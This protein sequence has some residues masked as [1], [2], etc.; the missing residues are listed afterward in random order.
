LEQLINNFWLMA[1]PSRL[2]LRRGH[3]LCCK[4]GS[5]WWSHGA[6]HRSLGKNLLVA[7][8]ASYKSRF[9][10][11]VSSWWRCLCVCACLGLI[12]LC[13]R[14]CTLLGELTCWSRRRCA[15]LV[16]ALHSNAVQIQKQPYCQQPSQHLGFLCQAAS[17]WVS[18]TI[19]INRTQGDDLQIVPYRVPILPQLV[20]RTEWTFLSLPPRV[21]KIVPP[22]LA[23][24]THDPPSCLSL[25]AELWGLPEI[26]AQQVRC[27]WKASLISFE[28]GRREAQ[29]VKGTCL[30]LAFYV[31]SLELRDWPKE[32]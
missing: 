12:V 29:L 4:T 26:V 8:P 31:L 1:I 9:W 32:F 14:G 30:L 3:Y 15:Y 10:T 6:W 13:W 11:R 16:A 22:L 27:R 28:P 7:L 17:L 24:T 20:R 21:V 19:R 25:K 5:W 23:S 18:N 2:N